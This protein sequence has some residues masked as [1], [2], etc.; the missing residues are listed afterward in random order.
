[1]SHVHSTTGHGRSGRRN[2]GVDCLLHTVVGWMLGC[3]EAPGHCSGGRKGQSEV[4]DRWSW[5]DKAR[6]I[7][8]SG[9]WTPWYC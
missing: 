6:A 8:L 9:S 7:W 2:T 3:S 5:F 1:M 4:Q